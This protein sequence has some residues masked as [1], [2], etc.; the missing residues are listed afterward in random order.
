MSGKTGMDAGKGAPNPSGIVG[1]GDK[2]YFC[3]RWEADLNVNWW[4]W[5]HQRDE[6]WK[7]LAW[8]GPGGKGEGPQS[9]P[10]GMKVRQGKLW[11]YGSIASHA[12]I[13]F[14]DLEKKSWHP[15]EGKNEQGAAVCGNSDPNKGKPVTDIAWDERTGDLYIVGSTG[16]M[17]NPKL[18]SPAA[19]GQVIRVD[20]DGVYHPMGTMLMPETP[21]A[22]NIQE[23]IW[24]DAS[25][26]PADIYIGGTFG[27]WGS[28]TGHANF[29]YNV[30]K[31][32]HADQDWR[33]IPVEKGDRVYLSELD[34]A[35]FPK[36]LPG[37]PA[38][39]T[40]T[41]HGFQQ[42]GFPRVRCLTMD[43]EGN[44]YAG[45][46][47][48]IV[49]GTFPMSER[50]KEETFGIAR[51]DAKAKAWGPCTRVGGVS[52]DV[53][54]M[55][56]LDEART[57]LLLTGSFFFDNAWTPLN[58]AAVL[59]VKTGDLSP[60]GGGFMTEGRSQVASPDV[61]HFVEGDDIWFTG[62]FDHVGVNANDLVDAPIES[63]YV[64]HWNASKNFDPNRG[65]AI[66]PV[67][68]VTAP[69]GHS[70]AQVKVTLTAKLGDGEGTIVWFERS[71]TGEWK[72]KGKGEKVSLDLRL[73]A[74]DGDQ[75][76]YVAVLRPDGTM[77]GKL[78]VRIPVVA[79]GK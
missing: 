26:E 27:F 49:T 24:I 66:D 47:L 79:G 71:K 48:G 69:A 44:I 17:T 50:M 15:L 25:K 68:P 10:S 6:G 63:A 52:R 59:D 51:Y 67:A 2:L 3:G 61:R 4:V 43:K 9:P 30:A 57:K 16:G 1:V 22:P 34:A 21:K 42:E 5:T 70:A 53:Y 40:D 72:E 19:V 18:G 73:K 35:K 28:E 65:L 32:S 77:G 75:T 14:Y 64:A 8:T 12:G 76:Y 11:V 62:G 41:F 54:Q 37:L 36:G 78:P 7:P 38:H 20:K 23:C 31:W 39:P 60:L 45:G 46:S 58:C 13:C 56:W 29:A 74:A 33:P 55:S